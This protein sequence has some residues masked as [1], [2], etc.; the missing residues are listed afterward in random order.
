M[1]NGGMVVVVVGGT[2]VVVEVVDVVASVVDVVVD[3]TASSAVHALAMTAR[4]SKTAI[5]R[6]MV[7]LANVVR[8]PSRDLA[9]TLTV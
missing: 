5:R 1:L 8:S 2:V 7:D 3:S 9:I 4:T 6:Y